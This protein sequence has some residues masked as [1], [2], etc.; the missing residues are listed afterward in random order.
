MLLVWAFV[1]LPLII[2][3]TVVAAGL[4]KEIEDHPSNPDNKPDFWK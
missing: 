3:F 4:Q 2:A 1:M